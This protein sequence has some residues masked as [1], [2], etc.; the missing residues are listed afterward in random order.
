MAPT[1]AKLE[2]IFW[3]SS[4][5]SYTKKCRKPESVISAKSL[6]LC[7]SK[8]LGS[9]TWRYS[10]R[11]LLSSD[12][13][14]TVCVCWWISVW[15]VK[16]AKAKHNNLRK[17][18]HSPPHS[19]TR[20]YIYVN[21]RNIYMHVNAMVPSE[22]YSI[23]IQNAVCA[24][25]WVRVSCVGIPR[26]PAWESGGRRIWWWIIWRFNGEIRHPCTHTAVRWHLERRG[27]FHGCLQNVINLR[28]RLE[29]GGINYFAAW[30][31]PRCNTAD[32]N[33]CK[34]QAFLWLYIYI[35]G[36]LE[37]RIRD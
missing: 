30:W 8:G 3:C 4:H 37:A 7:R 2:K 10:S 33:L 23:H 35:C 29:T 36:P 26:A 21:L 34:S 9:L 24:C 12:P 1:L 20:A 5:C 28:H 13:Y 18:N 6:L 27:C 17:K 25:I 32:G 22:W 11:A 14:Y 15:V 19:T 31:A 16:A